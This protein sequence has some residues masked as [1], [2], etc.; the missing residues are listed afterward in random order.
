MK[1]RKEKLGRKKRMIEGENKKVKA[2][3]REG[4]RGGEGERIRCRYQKKEGK[5]KREKEGRMEGEEES[6]ETPPP[7]AS[8]QL[9]S[10][11]VNELN[12]PLRPA[13]NGEGGETHQFC[14]CV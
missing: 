11:G 5:R 9:P 1:Q 13:S 6:R 14:K 8:N 4:R 2:S 10:S 3:V 12:E 7:S